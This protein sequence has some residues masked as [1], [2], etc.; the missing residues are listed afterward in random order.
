MAVKELIAMWKAMNK[1]QIYRVSSDNGTSWGCGPAD[2]SWHQGAIE[3]LVKSVKRCIKLPFND[4][5]LSLSELS[6]L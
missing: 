4:Q 3:S 5:R 6:A 1:D 2:S